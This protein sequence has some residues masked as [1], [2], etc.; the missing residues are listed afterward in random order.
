MLDTTDKAR[1]SISSFG[2]AK[3]IEFATSIKLISSP[4]DGLLTTHPADRAVYLVIIALTLF[5]LVGG[6][7]LDIMDHLKSNSAPYPIVIYIHVVA[8]VAWL[9]L[10][11]AQLLLVRGKRV[12]MHKQLGI[13]SF[14]LVP[15]LIPLN[16]LASWVFN[17]GQLAMPTANPQ[18]VSVEITE[19]AVFALL[20][21]SGLWLRKRDTAAHKRLLMLSINILNT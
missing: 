21:G 1:S 13:A 17:R 3:K 15:I 9:A 11:T 14:V 20:V 19:V 8:S 18:F 16:S 4:E 12:G 7:S 6:F 2:A 5:G 10:F